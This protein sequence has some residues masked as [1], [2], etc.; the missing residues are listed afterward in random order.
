MQYRFGDCELNTDQLT[1]RR[2]DAITTLSVQ[3]C[4]VLHYLIAHGDRIISKQELSD[5]L[6]P[7]TCIS[8][9]AIETVIKHVRRALGDSGRDQK[10]IQTLRGK[11]YRFI[12]PI[13]PSHPD[14]V[15]VEDHP[16][17]SPAASLGPTPIPLER[18]RVEPPDVAELPPRE[19][20]VVTALCIVLM[21]ALK[22]R[23]QVELEALHDLMQTLYDLASQSVHLYGGQLQPV[24]GDRLIAAFGLPVAQEDHALRAVL[25]GLDMMRRV[26]SYWD[27]PDLPFPKSLRL[28]MGIHTGEVIVSAVDEPPDRIAT[29]I[30]DVATVAYHLVETANPHAIFCSETTAHLLA[31][32]VALNA[33]TAVSL[34]G[35]A[36]P[37]GVYQCRRRIAPS[38]SLPA[39]QRTAIFVGRQHDMTT[40]TASLSHLTA[41]RGHVVSLVGSPGIGKSRLLAEFRQQLAG[42]ELRYLSGSCRSYGD[43]TPYLPILDLMRDYFHLGDGTSA[44][45]LKDHLDAGLQAL[46]MAPKDDAP[47]LLHLLGQSTSPG[48][49]QLE[50]GIL[51]MRLH[52]TLLHLFLRASQRQPLVL[53]IEDL[54][55]IDRTSEIYLNALIEQL[56]GVPILLLLSYRSGY[57]SQWHD[58]SYATQIAVHPLSDNDS[59]QVVQ[60][61]LPPT[62]EWPKLLIQKI[63]RQAEGNPFFLEELSRRAAERGPRSLTEWIPDTIQAV[64]AARMDQLPPYAKRVLQAAAVVDGEFT[65]PGLQAI[66]R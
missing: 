4:E 24:A 46:G 12:A 45:R 62:A 31:D 64:L 25:C 48:V 50:P 65:L 54:H 47:L 11:G 63:L 40:L 66:F 5:Q 35:Q 16:R 23:D 30:W 22:L 26:Q 61:I 6:W 10:V 53:E 60:A 39:K 1:L 15:S 58:K 2:A 3:V 13:I 27:Q 59:L 8:D 49:H 42:Q 28:R 18:P 9:G 56:A 36:K 33:E 7:S 20:K 19:R 29:A 41:G 52:N 37:L 34:P 57:R 55:W 21:D 51:K 17:L 32:Q 44:D 14:P 38:P 43:L